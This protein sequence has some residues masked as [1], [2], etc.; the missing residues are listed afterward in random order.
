MTRVAAWLRRGGR[1][2]ATLEFAIV[3]PLMLTIM[4]GIVGLGLCLATQIA[5]IVSA[6]EGARA[7]MA[8]LST[9]ERTSLATQAAQAALTGYLPFLSANSATI[10][11]Q[12]ASG[13]AGLFQ[14]SVRVP[15]P[16]AAFSPLVPL[17]ATLSSYT[18]VVSNGGY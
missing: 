4:M 11:A 1:A 2:T 16:A 3:L 12:P 10:S 18:A 14:V 15:F 17:P 5:V 6:Q 8:G 13:N 9:A 7:A